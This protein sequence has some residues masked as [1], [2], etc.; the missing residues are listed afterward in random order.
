MRISGPKLQATANAN[1]IHGFTRADMLALVMAVGGLFFLEWA[2]LGNTRFHGNSATCINNHQRLVRAWQLFAEDHDGELVGNFDGGNVQ[3]TANRDKTW[4]LGWYNFN[5]GN[6]A[7]TN[8]LYLT[9]DSPLAPYTGRVAEIFKCPS[10]LSLSGGTR[11]LPRVRSYSM[12]GCMGRKGMNVIWTPGFKVY[13]RMIDITDP[14][15]GGLFVFIDEREDSLNDACLLFDMNG[16]DPR[17]PSV[18]RIVDYPGS[19][20]NRGATLSFADGH[21]ESKRWLDPRTSPVLRP[22][23]LLALNVSSPNNVD[24]LWIQERMSRRIR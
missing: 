3:S 18:F 14:S 21:V 24:V 6:Q 4:V 1:V 17:E 22:G 16:F 20:H 12:N 13:D 7:T 23:Q 10:D 11:G 5:R 8:T 9:Q 19:Y 15:P 2:S